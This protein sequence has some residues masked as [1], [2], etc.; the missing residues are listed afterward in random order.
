[1]LKPPKI[2]PRPMT[3]MVTVEAGQP[4][5]TRVRF[6]RPEDEPRAYALSVEAAR[7]AEPLRSLMRGRS[8]D[9]ERS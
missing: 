5:R 1:M 6:D 3:L 2:T 8:I 9:R 4:V 7:L